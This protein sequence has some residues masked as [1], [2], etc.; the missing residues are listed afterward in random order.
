MTKILSNSTLSVCEPGLGFFFLG[1]SGSISCRRF[2]HCPRGI[3]VLS[4]EFSFTEPQEEK[5]AKPSVQQ[6]NIS[7]EEASKSQ[8]YTGMEEGILVVYEVSNTWGRK[9]LRT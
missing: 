4:F 5:M 9:T 2:P 8:P 6:I 1:S 3:R 7:K